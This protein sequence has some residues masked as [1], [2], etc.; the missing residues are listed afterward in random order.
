MLSFWKKAALGIALG[1]TTIAA[2]APAEAQRYRGGRHHDSTGPAIVAGI[3]GLA[4]GAAIAGSNRDRY[5]D[6]GDYYDRGYY[7]DGYR[8]RDG[9]YRNN[10]RQSYR[11]YDRGY[12]DRCQVRR[13]YDPYIGRHVRVRYC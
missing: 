10:Y 11:G 13:V 4:I 3:A 1:A 2:A 5:Y 7:D 12:Y 6:R 9:Y 8:Y